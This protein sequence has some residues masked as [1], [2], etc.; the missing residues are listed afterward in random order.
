MSVL[1]SH[2]LAYRKAASRPK[3]AGWLAVFL[4]V[5]LAGVPCVDAADPPKELRVAAAA[6]LRPVMPVLADAYE[7]ATGIKLV[8]SYGSSATLA[9]QI[10]NGAPFDVFLAANFEFP[11]KVIAANLADTGTPI[12]YARGTLVLWARK[13]SPLQPLQMSAL[14]DARAK[15]IAI[16]DEMHAPFG[17]AAIRALQ[18]LHE[19]DAVKA[20]LVRAEN[21]EQAA[22]FAESGNAQLAFLSLTLAKSQHMQ[23]IGSYVQVPALY[24]PIDQSAVVMRK[25][26]SRDAAH[27][28]LNWMLSPAIQANLKSFG[29][30][31]VK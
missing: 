13:D 22:Q 14:N 27:D 6:D 26:P 18:G 30:T 19:Y 5:A 12:V 9:T 20:R 31:P 1:S 17:M 3:L 28:F 7:H 23:E 8:V 16:A 24:P 10:L 29:L 11:E 25:S 15:S 4:L 2:S 21:V